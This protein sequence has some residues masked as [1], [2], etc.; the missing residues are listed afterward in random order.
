MKCYM[1]DLEGGD[2]E[3]VAICIVCGMGL[4]LEHAI[5][6]EI[7]LWA[8]VNPVPAHK[9]KRTLPRFVCKDC[10]DAIHQD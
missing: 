3:A 2:S 1:C 6:E 10:H 9:L 8:G 5:R 4:C 7:E